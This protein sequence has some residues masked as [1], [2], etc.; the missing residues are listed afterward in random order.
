M[1]GVGTELAQATA[2]GDQMMVNIILCCVMVAICVVLFFIFKELK[3]IREWL[4]DTMT[5]K[6][7]DSKM[8]RMED[9]VTEL[10][11]EMGR[12]WK[13]VDTAPVVQRRGGRD[14]VG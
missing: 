8:R 3:E 14:D 11:Q 9:I 10:K 6:Q 12:L 4:R 13:H 1:P 2:S 5:E 7:C